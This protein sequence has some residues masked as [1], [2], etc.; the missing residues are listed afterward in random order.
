MLLMLL[1][2]SSSLARDLTIPDP[3]YTPGVSTTKTLHTLCTTRLGTDRRYVTARMKARVFANYRLTG[4]DDDSQGCEVDA[5]GR[6]YE[7][8]HRV[9]RSLGGADEVANLW[10]QCMSGPWNAVMKDRLET[11]VSKELCEGNLNAQEAHELFTGDWRQAYCDY[12]PTEPQCKEL[13]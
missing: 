13:H 10:P 8:D 1:A 12:W 6:R 9:P 7:V 3:R 11:H 5:Y 4:N 2:S